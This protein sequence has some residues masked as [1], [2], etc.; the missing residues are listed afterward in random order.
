VLVLNQSYEPVSIC[1]VQKA[2]VLLFMEKAELIEEHQHRRIRS[3]SSSWPFP[4]IIRLGRYHRIL[5]KSIM[6]SR[7]NILRR[8]G[9]RC[10]YCGSSASQ[11]TVDHI[12]PRSRGG[13]DSWENLITACVKCNNAKG[14]RPLDKTGMTLL[15][16]PRRPSH[17]SFLLQSVNSIEDPW[18][19]YL[20][21]T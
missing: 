11:L 7:K 19:P 8:D 14:N 1:S 9:H 10:Q 17:V 16:R 15:S 12:T 13:T 21:Q 2:V 5:Y 20:F 6:L 18:K 3:V 4:S